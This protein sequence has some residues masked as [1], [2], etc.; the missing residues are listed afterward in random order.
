MVS[1]VTFFLFALVLASVSSAQLAHE[2]TKRHEKVG[3]A[4]IVP[5]S[6]LVVDLAPGTD[7]NLFAATHGL[8]VVRRFNALPNAFVM[9]SG[10]PERSRLATRALAQESGVRGVYP[11]RLI[12][13]IRHA[14]TPNDPY[15]AQG[16][17]DA[18]WPGQWHLVN[19]IGTGIDVNVSPA[20]LRDQTGNGVVVG[21]LD[22][23]IEATHPDLADNF[24]GSDSYDFVD[25]DADPTPGSAD[26]YHGTALAGLIAARG[27][28]GIGVT[29][30]APF[31]KVAGL[32]LD[33]FASTEADYADATLF[34]SSGGNT[35]IKVK[36]HSYGVLDTCINQSLER[37]A[38]AT[39]TAAGTIHVFSA[40]NDRGFPTQEV[41]KMMLQGSPYAITV[42]GLGSD[43]T[44][45]S[46]SGF[47]SAVFC[48]APAGTDSA[49]RLTTVD[50]S[51]DF[52]LNGF[53]VFPNADYTAEFGGTSGAAALVSGAL[54]IAKESQPNLNTR[55]AKHMLVRSCRPVDLADDSLE[56]DGGWQTNGAGF[57]FNPNYG[58]GLLDVDKLMTTLS[59]YVGVSAQTSANIG[60]TAVGEAIPDN[61]PNGVS[62]TF[63]I[64]TQ[65]PLEEVQIT[66]N[67]THPFRGDIEA[68]V[69]SPSGTRSRL[70]MRS[71][72]T[73]ADL[74]W[75]FTSNAF[76]GE[77]P[78]GT[79]TIKVCDASEFDEG[80]WNSFSA[81]LKMGTP[82][83]VDKVQSVALVPSAV[84]G[85]S[86]STARVTLAG[87]ARNGGALVALSSSTPGVA[88]VPDSVTVAAGATSATFSVST[89]AVGELTGVTISA[90]RLGVTATA[91]LTVKPP[92]PSSVTF[93]PATVLGGSPSTGTVTLNVPAPVGGAQVALSSSNT[94]AAIVP[95]SV[96]VPE[97]QTSAA[98]DVTTKPLHLSVNV[99]VTATYGGGSRNGAITVNR[100]ILDTLTLATSSVTGGAKVIGT[101]TLNGP[102]PVGGANVNLSS[103][104]ANVLTVPGTITVPG[105]QT[106][107]NFNVTT[108]PV[109][110]TVSVAITAV[111]AG[112]SKAVVLQVVRP[113]LVGVVLNPVF[114]G[115]GQN[116]NATVSLTGPAPAG[117]I[118]V[119]M[120]ASNALATPP[121]TL[122][123]PAG[124]A[125]AVASVATQTVTAT[126]TS[127]V[128]A[129]YLGVSKGATLNLQ[130]TTVASVSF[131][132]NSV[133]RNGTTQ[134]TVTLTVPAPA[135][136]TTVALSSS[137]VYAFPVPGTVAF[138]AG[139][140]VKSF[141]VTAGN[142]AASNITVRASKGGVT[143]TATVTVTP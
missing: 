5:T 9:D 6:Q 111:R 26:D 16:V 132:P 41:G 33:T 46:T 7:A 102:A 2:P 50:R 58:F 137:N 63:N 28:N 64:A 101:V 62:R 108:Y 109:A 49:D 131:A 53:D 94:S 19:S 128:W 76:W 124:Q 95:V 20:W 135:G 35:S 127:V 112:Q 116:V 84:F 17:P 81:S 96:T 39:S 74:N 30:I 43:G 15:F 143:V 121:A 88:S 60:T 140:T 24:D 103:G 52:G 27:G 22:D 126:S 89:V 82:I 99:A 65:T 125:S 92:I 61:N 123:I 78:A 56:S 14:F 93:N 72:D 10:S 118:E 68:Y 117:G 66:L 122:L 44:F 32:R 80:V 104:N 34:H 3:V 115:G 83:A 141:S 139:E 47:G 67:V 77:N 120:S 113:A 129:S 21:V 79:W 119:A 54:A 57:Q 23:G 87:P 134:G 51:G 85:G 105:L 12:R 38:L 75:T 91:I 11:N 106:S 55:F 114:A 25:N 42:A 40:G 71:D 142:V 69:T 13:R 73:N 31:A 86:T 70:C 90:T 36:N 8:A 98:F 45:I 130:P 107:R 136:G 59:Q 4:A 48:S 97:G 133:Q 37:D 110:S 138:A 29:G 18:Q 1:R 100:A